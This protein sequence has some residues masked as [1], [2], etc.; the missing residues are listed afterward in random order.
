[1]GDNG[2]T[3]PARL[4]ST[5]ITAVRLVAA[6]AIG[7][8]VVATTVGQWSHVR[9]TFHRLSWPLVG[10]SLVMA[11]LG[12]TTNAYAWRAALADLDHEVPIRSAGQV[13]LVGQLG[14][15]LPGSVW[16]YV[17]QMELGQRAGIPRA[18]A[19]LA[20][21]ISTGI[22]ITV[23]L[24]VG[25]L[26]L[27][28]TFVAGRSGDHATLARAAFYLALALLPIALVCAHPAV[29]SRLVG[30]LLRV[31]RRPPLDRPLSW[32]GVLRV[33]A[34][35]AAGYL[36]FGLHLWLLARSQAGAGWT[37]LGLCVAAVGLSISVST[38]VV[39]APSGLGVR[40]FLI[41]VTLMAVGLPYGTG[42]AIALA[43]RLVATVADVVAAGGAALNGV[44]R[45]RHPAAPS[46]PSGPDGSVGSVGPVNRPDRPGTRPRS[47][48]R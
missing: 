19:F 7:Y 46:D 3:R 4:R 29:L 41:A 14:K 2:D 8:F 6:V 48:R 32:A 1:M 47:A 24:A 17:L 33:A 9:D 15:Y 13:F 23:G 20:S 42:Y 21:L 31:L 35:S 26:G 28:G 38:F 45:V 39:L 27:R 36:F 43:S 10:L 30:L 40:E 11:L 37:G 44:R 34:W 5:L 22:G 18:R 16:S 12:I 25:A